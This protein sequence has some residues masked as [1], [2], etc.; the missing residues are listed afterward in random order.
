MARTH[1][2]APDIGA[3]ILAEALRPDAAPPVAIHVRPE[4]EAHIRVQAGDAAADRLAGIPLVVDDRIPSD[5]GY[6]IHRA[7]AP[8]AT[9]GFGNRSAAAS[10]IPAAA[11]PL[12]A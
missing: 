11:A 2:S 1:W 5:P 12:A 8:V 7:V 9:R 6:E 10:S 4:I 3:D